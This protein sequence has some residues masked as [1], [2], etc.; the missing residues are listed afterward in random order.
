[1]NFKM[2]KTEFVYLQGIRKQKRK[3][4]GR[5][6]SYAEKRQRE[7]VNILRDMPAAIFQVKET[8]LFLR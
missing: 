1:M 2:D 6:F 4:V 3:R 7:K 5:F 8:R